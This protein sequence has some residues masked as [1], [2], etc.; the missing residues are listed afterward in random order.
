[1]GDAEQLRKTMAALLRRRRSE[2]SLTRDQHGWVALHALAEAAG[3]QLDRVVS[4]EEVERAARAAQAHDFIAEL[5]DGY[6][7]MIGERGVRLSGGQKQRVAIARAVLIDPRVLIFDDST[8]AVDAETE[9]RIQQ[10]LNE[11]L[12]G[13]TAFVIAQRVSTV[14]EADRILLLEGGRIVEQGGHV[15]L[16]QSGGR[17]RELCERQLIRM[18]G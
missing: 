14:R 12:R 1:M 10:A 16:M 15:A 7:T 8:S 17:Y 11:L 3:T 4:V 9:S 18:E 2:S 5:P 6:E 13:R